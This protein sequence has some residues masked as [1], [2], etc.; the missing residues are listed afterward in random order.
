MKRE[1]LVAANQL[2]GVLGQIHRPPF[3]AGRCRPEYAIVLRISTRPGATRPSPYSRRRP[4]SRSAWIGAI[5]AF[6]AERLA[7]HA[8]GSGLD[9][10]R[11][12]RLSTS[13]FRPTPGRADELERRARA[14]VARGPQTASVGLDDRSADREAHAHSTGLGG[15]ERIEQA[16]HLVWI[17]SDPGVLHDHENGVG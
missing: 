14:G 2:K 5:P 16:R 4:G 13:C 9:P 6:G 1:R 12:E 8:F 7:D 11:R 3:S 10:R 15:E 17:E